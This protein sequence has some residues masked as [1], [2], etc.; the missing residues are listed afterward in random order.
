MTFTADSG[1]AQLAEGALTVE[2]DNAQANGS[3]TNSVK[4]VVTDAQGN[5]LA[6]QSVSFSADNGATIAASGV[7]GEDGS[8]VMTLTNTTAGISAVTATISGSSQ[9]VSVTFVA[10]SGTAQLAEGSLTV[11]T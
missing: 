10:D 5:A 11:E 4:A 3:A 7:T 9:S 1:T 2:T 6:N 8:V